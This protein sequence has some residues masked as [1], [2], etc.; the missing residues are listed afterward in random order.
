MLSFKSAGGAVNE[1]RGLGL[2]WSVVVVNAEADFR[3]HSTH[4]NIVSG[5]TKNTQFVYTAI[6]VVWK[7]P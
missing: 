1:T 3:G 2:G 7:D 6:L 5:C 4:A